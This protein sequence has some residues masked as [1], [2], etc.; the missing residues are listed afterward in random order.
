MKKTILA[1]VLMMVLAI[2]ITT[3]AQVGI[4]VSTANINPS[5]QLD[6]TSTTKGFLPPRMTYA[7]RNAIVNASAGLIIYCTD[8][9]SNG[10]EPECYNGYAWVSMNG[11]SALGN[12]PTLAP[13]I[14]IT[15]I[16]TVSA[17]SGGNIIYDGGV[18]VIA[19]GVVWSTTTGPTVISN[20][21]I[22]TNGTG[23]GI[24]SSSIT[25]LTENTTYYVRSYALNNVGT[26]YGQEVVFTTTLDLTP[27]D[28]I[29]TQLWTTLN[30]DVS[31]YRNG[32]PIPQVTDPTVWAG[33]TTGAW[34]YHNNDP[35]TGAIYGK[36]Y[37]W[38]AVNDSRGLAPAGFHIPTNAEWSALE[39]TLGADAGT[40]MKS[41]SGWNNG[42]NGTNSSG[43][44]GLPGGNRSSGGTFYS[45]GYSGFWWSS[46]ENNTSLAWTRSLYY[47]YNNVDKYNNNKTNGFSVR[48]LK[49]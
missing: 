3:N 19:R 17:T 20:T 45:I 35:A 8:F 1:T 41:T 27:R 23:I 21:G 31:T 38:Y 44:A 43:F 10:G 39:T 14:S 40:K 2:T 28:T 30:L 42:G 18:S 34:C 11:A 36:L 33:L 15:A 49:D 4:G 16:G 13:T 46:T 37:N 22:T 12:L 6:V 25:G 26:S 47:N 29:G 7:E 48:C 32:D 24:Y 9:G 5:A